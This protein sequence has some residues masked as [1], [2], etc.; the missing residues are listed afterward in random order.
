MITRTFEITFPEE[1]HLDA[2]MVYWALTMRFASENPILNE[3]H[4]KMLREGK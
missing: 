4:V 3:I 2:A 1:L